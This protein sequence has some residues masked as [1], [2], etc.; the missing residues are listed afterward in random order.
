MEL[1]DVIVIGGGIAGLSAALHLAE[2]GLAPV[3]VEAEPQYLGGRVGGKPGATLPGQPQEVFPAEHGIHGFWSQYRNLGGMLERH[4][5]APRMQTATRQEW[6]HGDGKRV[7][8]VELGRTTRRTLWPAPFHYGTMWF[9]PS[10]WRMI[11]WRDWLA[12]PAVMGSL[13]VATGLDPLREGK[14]LEG[15]T[16]ADF[17][18]GWSPQMRSFVATLARSGLSAHP[19][20]VPLAGFISFLRFYTILR[21][22]SQRYDYLVEDADKALIQPLVGRIKELGGEIL[23]GCR[24][25][26]LEKFGY[27]WQISYEKDGQSHV[28]QTRQ[29]ILA[30]DVSAARNL[31]QNCEA[32][33]EITGKMHFP[34]GQ[35]TV[36]VRL[37][38][39]AAP[40]KRDEAGILSGDFTADN[41]FW[42]HRFQ[43]VF[44]SW[45]K[46]T[47]GSALEAHIYGPPDVLALPDAELLERT[48]ADFGRIYPALAGKLLHKTIR[49]NPPN[50]TLFAIGTL[51]DH[52]GVRTPFPGLSCCGDW[53]RHTTGALF[54]ERA[55][56]TGIEAANAALHALGRP[57]Y[58]LV[59]HKPPELLARVV[60]GWVQMTRSSVRGT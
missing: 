58:E 7:R 60:G 52:L 39:T 55:C 10:F 14:K 45:H 20:A 38:Y 35:E 50:H 31:L 15:K 54:L 37:W 29:L 53:V 56:I 11:S 34:P 22:D 41:F 32:T 30:T 8:R 33:R 28:L 59:P 43:E 16:L 40:P 9:R 24:V 27:V 3:V 18:K 13:V 48:V 25:T 26:A 57:T 17:C 42:L 4:N 36:V 49:R 47:G 12:M 46:R 44:Q 5:I 21:R 6:V 23:P 1:H 51:S 19:E 2:S